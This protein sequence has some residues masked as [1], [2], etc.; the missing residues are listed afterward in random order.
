MH[1]IDCNYIPNPKTSFG[2][3]SAHRF[4]DVLFPSRCYTPRF[5]TYISIARSLSFTRVALS[6]SRRADSERETERGNI[7]SIAVGRCLND[8]GDMLFRDRPSRGLVNK[9]GSTNHPHSKK[10][11]ILRTPDPESN[12]KPFPAHHLLGKSAGRGRGGGKMT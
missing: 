1:T 10:S 9:K 11:K 6:I 5:S 4:S 12:A 7:L 2:R 8:G 3:D